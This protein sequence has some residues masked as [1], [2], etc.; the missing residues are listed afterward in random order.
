MDN[1][2]YKYSISQKD[3]QKNNKKIKEIKFLQNYMPINKIHFQS[4]ISEY[5]TEPS[6]QK[7]FSSNCQKYK[8]NIHPKSAHT[9]HL[10]QISPKKKSN[11][12]KAKN[13]S[14]VNR[15]RKGS[16]YNLNIYD[17]FSEK[18]VSTQKKF[19]D[20]KNNKIDTLKRELSLI[21]QEINLYEKKNINT[22]SNNNNS[23]NSHN[24]SNNSSVN[25]N[26][27]SQIVPKI[28]YVNKNNNKYLLVNNNNSYISISPFFNSEIF[29]NA[30]MADKRLEKKLSNLLTENNSENNLKYKTNFKIINNNDNKKNLL[31]IMYQSKKGCFNHNNNNYDYNTDINKKNFV[32][33]NNN[34]QLNIKKEN[35]FQN[36]HLE[37][38][39]NHNLYF[40]TTKINDKQVQII[41]NKNINSNNKNDINID[42][43]YQG[44]ND[45]LNK[46]FNCLFDYY[47]KNNHTQKC[48]KK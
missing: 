29:H 45:K 30:D 3:N 37:K 18:V 35:N 25:K 27:K 33:N 47:I 38:E 39:I 31:S 46:I 17:Y 32:K 28:L 20:Y 9:N 12:N 24:S 40:Y 1:Q 23:S 13:F 11:Q 19:I 22:N 5:E 21:K 41:E 48:Q 2:M 10:N 26:N 43:Q 14:N 42:E 16:F 44:I 15:M 4:N 8:Q 7:N 36:N 6:I 34:N